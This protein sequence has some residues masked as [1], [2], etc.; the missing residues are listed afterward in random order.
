MLT[1]FKFLQTFTSKNPPSFAKQPLPISTRSNFFRELRLN[2]EM[3][4]RQLFPILRA[5][6]FFKPDVSHLV[7]PLSLHTLSE[8]RIVS[9]SSSM[10]NKSSFSLIT[11]VFPDASNAFISTST[12]SFL[13]TAGAFTT[14]IGITFTLIAPAFTLIGITFTLIGIT[15]T[16]VVNALPD[17]PFCFSDSFSRHFDFPSL[18]IR[19]TASLTNGCYASLHS[20][21]LTSNN[22]SAD[23]LL[24]TSFVKH[25]FTKSTKS[26][27][28]F[29]E[30]REGGS[31]KQIFCI[32]YPSSPLLNNTE[33]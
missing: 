9:T 24:S 1:L 7:M 14:L 18:P 28:H 23:G 33:Y 5:L 22:T 4:W 31:W 13:F 8:N 10:S 29:D 11:F 25:F 16:L 3:C 30:L 6:R 15:F 19:S 12:F 26:E 20:P 32:N 27:D 2:E 17:T 21:F